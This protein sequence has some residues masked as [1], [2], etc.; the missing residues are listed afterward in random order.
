MKVK[1]KNGN[2]TLVDAD[3]TI[4]GD[5]M[6]VSPK[7]SFNPKNGD[8]IAIWNHSCKKWMIAIVQSV[9]DTT[10]NVHVMI[11]GM[12][13]IRVA[14]TGVS[15][16]NE[17][18]YATKSEKTK[19]LNK[20]MEGGFIWDCDKKRIFQYTPKDGEVVT[21]M[22]DDLPTIYIY[23]TG[24]L[25]NT[26]YYAAYSTLNQTTFVSNGTDHLNGNRKDIRPATEQEKQKLF[27]KL[28]EK[29]FAWDSKKKEIVKLKWK[30][31][32]DEPYFFPHSDS[33]GFYVRSLEWENT[34][35]ENKYYE[36]GWIYKT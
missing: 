36:K 11:N 29:G 5:V 8:V 13:T 6:I 3:W 20:L 35:P 25:H 18:R 15:R 23:R 1:I 14:I 21:Y 28:A 16:N 27:D 34:R 26:S 9:Q 17:D 2:G 19:L 30:P 10:Y 33:S 31:K 12:D 24:T 7:E 32:V 4:E 22:N